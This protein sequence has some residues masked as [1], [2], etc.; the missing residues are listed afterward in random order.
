MWNAG[1][2]SLSATVSQDERR[3]K[4]FGPQSYMLAMPLFP[5]MMLAFTVE[6][7]SFLGQQKVAPVWC[8]H[9]TGETMQIE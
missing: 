8:N 3:Q 2:D 7:A 5:Y 4:V 6:T 9:D 1:K